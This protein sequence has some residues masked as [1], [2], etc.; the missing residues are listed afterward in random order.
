MTERVRTPAVAAEGWSLVLSIHIGKNT[1]TCNAN[2]YSR[3]F[4]WS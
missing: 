4:N 1:A 2:S 3:D